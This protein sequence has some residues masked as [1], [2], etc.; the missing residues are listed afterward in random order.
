LQFKYTRKT[1]K[2]TIFTLYPVERLQLGIGT[3]NLGNQ[4]ESYELY[5]L[6]L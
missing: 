1:E 6:Y 3:R 4:H 5:E 2:K